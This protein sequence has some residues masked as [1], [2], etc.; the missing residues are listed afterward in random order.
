MKLYDFA[1]ALA[2]M[3]VTG[4]KDFSVRKLLNP[5]EAFD[6]DIYGNCL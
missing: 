2:S 5:F 3:M 6:V 4:G 1:G